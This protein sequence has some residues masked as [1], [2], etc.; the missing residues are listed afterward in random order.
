MV[1][2]VRTYPSLLTAAAICDVLFPGAAQASRTEAPGLMLLMNTGK[3]L[4]WKVIN[5]S[6]NTYSCEKKFILN[7]R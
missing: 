2:N 6:I 3:Q 5:I 4:A 7:T 1:N